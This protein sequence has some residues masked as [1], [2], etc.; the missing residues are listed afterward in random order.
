MDEPSKILFFH[1]LESGPH[2]TKYRRLSEHFDV[3]AY[4][5]EGM[6]DIY[7]RLKKAEKKTRG[8]SDLVVVGSS[9]GGLLAA[10]LYARHPQRFRSYV[11]MAPALHRDIAGEI[12]AMPDDAQ[13]IHGLRDDVVP[14]EEVRAVC[15][16]HGLS[17]TEVDDEH[18]LHE[19]L[20]RMVEA[21][22]SLLD[23]GPGRR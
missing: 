22:R 5:F 7:D 1:G 2:G 9:F 12:T 19:S 6:Y 18:P 15:A 20:D 23:D 4:D 13:V 10:L 21:V 8:M 16:E 17:I 11:L 3:V 14:I